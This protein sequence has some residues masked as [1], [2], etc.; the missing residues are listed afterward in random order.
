MRETL[1]YIKS[2]PV[3]GERRNLA[4]VAVVY[5]Q[6]SMK[7][8]FDVHHAAV[9]G[10]EELLLTSGIP[11]NALYSCDLKE[12]INNYR[13]VILPEV[14][15]LRESEAAIVEQYVNNGGSILILGRDCGFFTMNCGD[16]GLIRACYKLAA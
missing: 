12:Q 16:P 3:F 13:L 11:H 2:L 6:D 5:H 14:R 15:L 10:M 4:E 1:K 9:H 7:L 8:D